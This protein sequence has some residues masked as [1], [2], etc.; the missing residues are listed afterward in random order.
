[1]DL[2]AWI[3]IIALVLVVPLSVI[4]NV[5]SQPVLRNLEKR[6]LVKINATK[7]QAIRAYRLIKSFHTRTRDRYPYYMQLAGW[8][9]I[10]AVGSA[11]CIILVVLIKPDI[12]LLGPME[13]VGPV[14]VVLLLL[15]FAFATIAMF[16]MLVLYT[17]ARQLDRFE[18]YKK[19]LE[20][21]W[22]PIDE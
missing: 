8:A 3:S 2:S 16:L 14:P 5:L 13:G 15:A 1:M 19:E 9:L 11:T 12:Q 20:Q 22:G 18:D 21:Q 7:L 4:A 6:K 10:F 17:T